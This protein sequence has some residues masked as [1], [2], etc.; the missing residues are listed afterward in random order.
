[1]RASR[2]RIRRSVTPTR[3]VA[4]MSRARMCPSEPRTEDRHNDMS[5]HGC[6]RCVGLG[7]EG[8]RQ[9]SGRRAASID[10]AGKCCSVG[11]GLVGVLLG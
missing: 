4:S 7:I 8:L 9:G 6:N 5:H 1:M 11:W 2:S 3:L 10:A